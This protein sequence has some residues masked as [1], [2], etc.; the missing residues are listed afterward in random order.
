MGGVFRAFSGERITCFWFL[1]ARSLVLI[2]R[3]GALFSW[4][5]H[6]MVLKRSV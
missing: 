4:G 2:L 3:H 6:K 5:T 1:G